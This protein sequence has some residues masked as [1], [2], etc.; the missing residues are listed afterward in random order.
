MRPERIL[1]LLF[2][3][4]VAALPARAIQL[5]DFS[6][7]AN[8]IAPGGHPFADTVWV[9]FDVASAVG[10]SGYQVTLNQLGHRAFTLL[11]T[12]ALDPEQCP[13]GF[14]WTGLDT[15]ESIVSDGAYDL[16]LR[17]HDTA[18]EDADSTGIVVD[19]TPPSLSVSLVGGQEIFRNG[20]YLALACVVG[21]VP[22]S[23]W[24]DFSEVD[25]DTSHWRD[26]LISPLNAGTFGVLYRISPLN[27]RPDDDGYE[28]TVSVRD[29]LR[30]AAS[31]TAAVC[32]SNAPP[33]FESARLVDSA[34]DSI[35]P[36]F[37][38]TQGDTIRLT[39]RITVTDPAGLEIKADFLEVDTQFDL[40][41]HPATLD[42]AVTTEIPDSLR[43]GADSLYAFWVDAAISYDLHPDNARPEG[44]YDVPIFVW[45]EGCGE[46]T[47]SV[48]VSLADL[49]PQPPTLLSP[50]GKTVSTETARLTGTAIGAARVEIRRDGAVIAE[51]EPDT[52]DGRFGA[53]VALVP[54][55]NVLQAV[56]FDAFNHASDPSAPLEI[57]RIDSAVIELEPRM[58]PGDPIRVALL[59]PA[60]R[61][62]LEIFNLSGDLLFREAADNPGEVHEF[63]WDGRNRSGDP[64][65]SGP[66][67]AHVTVHRPEGKMNLDRAF[68]FTRR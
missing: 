17:V 5:V 6:V 28:V 15:S 21:E 23:I 47:W 43:V 62:V 50:A 60:D 66:Y 58:R 18:G 24:V 56:A 11:D 31:A 54:G 67:I 29:T 46:D 32:L 49:G 63:A 42:S 44:T 39:A 41:L 45:D 30:N 1:W 14:A 27:T 59:G 7:S 9:S 3:V 20:D 51:A 36:G 13:C 65:L 64:A 68:V 12:T 8:A 10:A 40:I 55:L 38:Y 37:T 35:P 52:L 2:P 22:D 16:V 26:Y 34:G 25:G 61:M 57:F 53:T 48:T 33:R 19:A 4:F